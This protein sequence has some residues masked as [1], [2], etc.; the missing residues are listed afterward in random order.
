M[1]TLTQVAP[2]PSTDGDR[3]FTVLVVDDHPAVRLGIQLLLADEPGIDRVASAAS[4]QEGLKRAGELAPD[5]AVVDF[6]LPE[7]D[8]LT[9]TRR[10]GAMPNPPRI[11]LFSA[12][13]DER[14]ALAAVLAGADAMLGKDIMGLELCRRIE[15]LARGD[16]PQFSISPQALAAVSEELD[17]EDRPILGM[18]AAGAD[19]EEITTVLGL[20]VAELDLRRSAMLQCLKARPRLPRTRS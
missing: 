13:A 20:S 11:L 6:H 15:A 7:R 1:Q 4:Y 16:K 5:V 12:Y 9:L 14:L 8:G 18:L 2:T 10:L 3:G 17:L 19:Q